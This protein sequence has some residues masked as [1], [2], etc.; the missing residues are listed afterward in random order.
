MFHHVA[1]KISYAVCLKY[2]VDDGEV[3]SKYR[4]NAGA[5]L[6][7]RFAGIKPRLFQRLCQFAAD[8]RARLASILRCKEGCNETEQNT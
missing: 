1:Q 8:R 4:A 5:A 2:Y 3:V 6:P 7:T